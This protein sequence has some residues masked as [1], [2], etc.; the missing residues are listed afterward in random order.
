M[1]KISIIIL[2]KNEEKHIDSTLGAVF[3][4]NTDQKYEVILIDSGSQDSTLDIARRYPVKILEIPTGKFGHGLTRNR[5]ARLATGDI[6]V[7]LNAD[8]TPADECWLKGLVE[9]FN[10]DERI[11]GIYSC[12][13]P[14]QDC[15]PLRDWEILNENSSSRQVRYIKDFN[16]YQRMK[17]Q[18]K[19]AFLSFNSIS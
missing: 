19:R 1:L 13:L 9:A 12:I 7:F 14:R 5:G 11:A 8:A 6:V 10:D 18:E 2:S 3:K 17:P 16:G 15:N 4:Q